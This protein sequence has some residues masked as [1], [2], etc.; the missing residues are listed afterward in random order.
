MGAP[1]TARPGESGAGS[2]RTQARKR[3]A[4]GRGGEIPG[5]NP[6]PTPQAGVSLL[7]LLLAPRHQK[8]AKIHPQPQAGSWNARVLLPS[9][10][11]GVWGGEWGGSISASPSSSRS[12]AEGGRREGEAQ[13]RGRFPAKAPSPA[14]SSSL[15]CLGSWKGNEARCWDERRPAPRRGGGGEIT[16]R[17]AS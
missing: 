16:G 4:R 9:T 13:K 11:A 6:L 3:A 15:L 7:L 2:A 17:H 12:S 8:A 5:S 1:A 14:S 10:R